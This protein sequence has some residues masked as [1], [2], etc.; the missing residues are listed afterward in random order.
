MR[1]VVPQ[2]PLLPDC[3]SDTQ[4]YFPN[5]VNC[6]QYFICIDRQPVLRD[7]PRGTIWDNKTLECEK[8]D[9]EV[10]ARSFNSRTSSFMYSAPRED[11]KEG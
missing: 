3:T 9:S 8:S 11:E 4:N 10:C 6:K 7:C 2:T 5:L 1:I